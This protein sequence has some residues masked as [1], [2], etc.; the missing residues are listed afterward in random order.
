MLLHQ[1]LQN[2]LILNILTD[3]DLLLLFCLKFYHKTCGTMT[4]FIK[5]HENLLWFLSDSFL[6]YNVLKITCSIPMQDFSLSFKVFILITICVSFCLENKT[7]VVTVQKFYIKRSY[8]IKPSESLRFL[9]HFILYV[10]CITFLLV[11]ISL[12]TIL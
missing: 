2:V 12:S 11:K 10:I 4:F 8:W 6:T 7:F 5:Q 9:V 1:P 3:F